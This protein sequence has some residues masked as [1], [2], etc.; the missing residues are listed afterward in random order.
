MAYTTRLTQGVAIL[1]SDTQIITDVPS[2]LDLMATTAYE[3][4][5]TKLAIPQT[6]I[7]PDF[8]K[9]STGFAGEVAQKIVN[10]RY[11]L[12][13]IGDFSAYTSKPLN[14]YMGECNR[15]RHLCF[16]ADEAA[17]LAWLNR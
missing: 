15:G 11:Q 9:L 2:V 16:V 14:D 3:Y 6:A 17:A 5:V 7:N 8:F 13:I 12:A 4:N 1:A 10:Y